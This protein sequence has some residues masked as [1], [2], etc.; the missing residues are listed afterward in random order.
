MV[1][2]ECSAKQG[3]N[4]KSLFKQMA[5]DIYEAAIERMNNDSMLNCR[6][7]SGSMASTDTTL[8]QSNVSGMSVSSARGLKVRDNNNK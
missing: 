7:V 8:Q 6:Q 3:R 4:I 1:Y 5:R 2:L